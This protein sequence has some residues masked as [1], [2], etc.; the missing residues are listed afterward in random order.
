MLQS[1]GSQR[2]RHDLQTEGTVIYMFDDFVS[3]KKMDMLL[4]AEH[5]EI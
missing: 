3:E 5:K 2:V 1:M 4:T